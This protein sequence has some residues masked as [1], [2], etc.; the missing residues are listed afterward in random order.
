[1]HLSSI[2][3]LN[4]YC[5]MAQLHQEPKEMPVINL[6]EHISWLL[7]LKRSNSIRAVFKA[8]KVHT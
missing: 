2:F 4:C 7:D 5:F 3:Q 6:V 8:S 1:M